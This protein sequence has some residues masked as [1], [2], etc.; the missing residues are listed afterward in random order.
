MNAMKKKMIPG[1][2]RRQVNGF[3]KSYLKGWGFF[4]VCA[5][6]CSIF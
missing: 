6:Q 3:L 4:N 2:T 1:M 5:L